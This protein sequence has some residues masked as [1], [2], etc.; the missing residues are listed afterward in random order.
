LERDNDSASKT[1]ESIIN[2][3]YYS[4]RHRTKNDTKV[5]FG[6]STV[7]VDG[8]TNNNGKQKFLRYADAVTG[9]KGTK[10]E[11]SIKSHTS[12]GSNNSPEESLQSLESTVSSLVET[13]MYDYMRK[14]ELS[15]EID[16]KE[17]RK[18]RQEFMKFEREEARKER[19]EFMYFEREES[20]KQQ[21]EFMDSI[22]EVLKV[23][24]I[25]Q[26]GQASNK[27]AEAIA[28]LDTKKAEASKPIGIDNDTRT[29]ADNIVPANYRRF[30]DVALT[31]IDDTIEQEKIPAKG[32]K[33][34]PPRKR[35]DISETPRQ[36][37]SIKSVNKKVYAVMGPEI[38]KGLI[39]PRPPIVPTTPQRKNTTLQNDITTSSEF[40]N[41]CDDMMN[42]KKEE[43]D[44]D[45]KMR[46]RPEDTGSSG[47]CG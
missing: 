23:T 10:N 27:V 20:R 30:N 33:K 12:N 4:D 34:E 29:R 46:G 18:E 7:Y 38:F 9:N 43:E 24:Q 26:S 11:G 47:Q 45:R 14:I 21:K 35:L 17:A 39:Q 22:L 16:R 42:D 13:T 19:Q 31:T 41:E 15:R 28:A 3:K 25:A 8:T 37:A 6:I 44:K 5:D 32:R 1:E 36:F 2:D 40:N